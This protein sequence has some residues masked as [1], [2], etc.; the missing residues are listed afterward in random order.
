PFCG[1]AYAASKAAVINVMRQAAVELAPH[2][3][4]VNAIAPGF[5]HT[6]IG[7]G[8][9]DDAAVRDRLAARVPLGR[10]GQPQELG[11]LTLLLASDA[12]SYITG[13]VIPVDGGVLA[14]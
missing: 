12:G 6:G 13:T 3:I 4:L 7:G 2:G 14:G 9:L 1:Y 10:I 5:I 8:R 11:G